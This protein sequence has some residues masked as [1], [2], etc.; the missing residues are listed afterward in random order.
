[1]PIA[2]SLP[3]VDKLIINWCLLQHSKLSPSFPPLPLSTSCERSFP[4]KT[5]Q[6]VRAI[7]RSELCVLESNRDV[8]ADPAELE[9][10]D[11]FFDNIVFSN[12]EDAVDPSGCILLFCFQQ[13]QS[14]GNDSS[15]CPSRQILSFW[16]LES[17]SSKFPWWSDRLFLEK[18]KF[19]SAERVNSS[20]SSVCFLRL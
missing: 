11:I 5:F 18:L 16:Q 8:A 3:K 1:M 14:S 4:L 6:R 2:F 10:F 19:E 17:I 7:V 13:R 20:W 12:L 15:H 9:L